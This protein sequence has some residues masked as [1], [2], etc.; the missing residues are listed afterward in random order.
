MAYLLLRRTVLSNAPG[1]PL[2]YRVTE[3]YFDTEKRTRYPTQFDSLDN[4]TFNPPR[5]ARVYDYEYAPGKT[6]YVYADGNGSVYTEN[7]VTPVQGGG[8]SLK[9]KL[10][11]TSPGT[12]D[13]N[14]ADAC[15]DLTGQFGVAP[16]QLEVIGQKGNAAGYYKTDTSK[17]EIYPVRFYNL[18]T[19]QYLLRVTDAMGAIA[20]QLIDIGV[21][22][23]GYP[24]GAILADRLYA[25]RLYRR[26]WLMNELRVELRNYSIG[27][28]KDDFARPYGTL[29][30]GYLLPGSNGQTWRQVYADG[31]GGVFEEGVYFVDSPTTAASS[32]ELENLILFNPTSGPEQNGGC[33]VEVRA[34]APPL[35]F[36]LNGVTNT[37]GRFDSLEAGMHSVVVAD[38][39]GNS[40]TVSFTLTQRYAVHWY[41]DFSD[42]HGVP[43]R[44]E[45][46]ERDYK[47][48]PV[49][50][51]GQRNPVVIKSDGLNTS[52]GGQ[53]D[54]PPVVGTSCQLSLRVKLGE[55]EDL[56][57]GDDRLGR[58]DVRRAGQLQFRG[59]VQPSVYEGELQDGL[60]DVSVLATDGLAGLK[61][62]YFTGHNGQRLTGYRPIIN[63]L[64]HCLSR[65]EVSLPLRFF[66]NSRDAGMATL[67]APEEASATNRTG[68]YFPDKDEPENCRTVV[69]A[70]AQALRGT[71][72]QREGTWQLRSIL[73]AA[74]DAAGRAY[75]P[76]GTAQGD[77]VAVA[78]S[79]TIQPPQVGALHWLR[80]VEAQKLS[81]RQSWK[82]LTGSTDTGWLK[83]AYSAGDVFSDRY[84]W[85]DD[86]SQLRT[87][88]GW[89][90]LPQLPFPLVLVRAGEK[91]SDLVTQWVRSLGLSQRD[92]RYLQGPALPLVGG[93]EATP[94]F[95]S[96]TGRVVPTETYLDYEGNAVSSPTTAAVGT[97]PYE[98]LVDGHSLGVQL[99]T[100]KLAAD[101]KDNTFEV[102]LA[103]LPSGTQVATLR[104]YSWLAP[105]TNLFRDAP[106]YSPYSDYKKGDV[107]RDDYA[108]GKNL[109]VARRD[110]AK[111]ATPPA[112]FLPAD[113]WAPVQPV[114]A[115]TGNLLLSSIGVQ[116]RP[117]GVTWDGK[118]N[119][120]ADGPAGTV[121][122]TEV[123]NV[124]HADVPISTG[125]FSGNLP[126]FGKTVANVDGTM[127]TSWSRSI[128][129][130]PAPL[131]ESVVL[132]G[133]SLRSGNS[134]L[135]TGALSHLGTE[136]IYLLDT[137]DAPTDVPG[138]RFCVG[139]TEWSLKLGY[140]RVSL[141]ENGAGADAPD[142]YANL[143]NVRVT[144]QLY[145]YKPAFF[146]SVARG[147]HD[148]S[149]RVRD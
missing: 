19:G 116:L 143:S 60:V 50:I 32:L 38:S 10:L 83:N 109:F 120:R 70:L 37:T 147:T 33:V 51:K 96:F 112:V 59:Y 141:I 130:L 98:I 7:Q 45:I 13:Q 2:P 110:Q 94:A 105:D 26:W 97:L 52:L 54:L 86:M 11:P 49:L 125:L 22:F 76:A 18:A 15:L 90:A 55:L 64:L 128:D 119:F 134:K 108:T 57:V 44:L 41:L 101:G 104:V 43:C 63:S 118:D 88:T 23:Y 91:G 79:G 40:I 17:L 115:A 27:Q 62:T 107:V 82:S 69:D 24:R 140:T 138:R 85:L 124:Y 100:L 89:V 73:E 142:P 133:L 46:W 135:L 106:S 80:S 28:G 35:R 93:L 47:G 9:L 123:L 68:Y 5:G 34:S 29:V 87:I 99:A 71:L 102:P 148:G 12:T 139:S 61:G 65:C 145:E 42:L 1:S 72:V 74:T 14:V 21:T 6:R 16:Y 113:E 129:L 117:Q 30:D 53:G 81:T 111:F 48:V 25:G 126:A 84:A 78:P 122:P 121:R 4:T 103:P 146:A 58:V 67:D 39:N 127:T 132:D 8:T 92:D 137:L 36:T 56:T 3:I 144:H 66:T 114:N 77:L 20:T 31:V 131:F 95:L 136:P 149:L 75:L